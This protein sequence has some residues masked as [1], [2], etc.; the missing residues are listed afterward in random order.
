M[1]P[2]FL[3]TTLAQ[4]EMSRFRTATQSTALPPEGVR[5]LTLQT[6]P[7]M[8]P[9]L[10]DPGQVGSSILTRNILSHSFIFISDHSAFFPL[11][12]RQLAGLFE[13]RI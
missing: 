13:V 5:T 1:K 11:L 10:R 4:Y 3:A 8:H 6:R 9:D 2:A 12:Q 7:F